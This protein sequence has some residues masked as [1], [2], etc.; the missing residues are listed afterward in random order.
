MWWRSPTRCIHCQHHH[1]SQ[2]SLEYDVV[3]S[4][5]FNVIGSEPFNVI[6]SEPFNCLCPPA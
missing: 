3:G 1:R 6:G 2:F 5:P 4:E